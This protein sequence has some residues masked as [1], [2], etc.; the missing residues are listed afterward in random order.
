MYVALLFVC[1]VVRGSHPGS[2]LHLAGQWGGMTR[3]LGSLLSRV[4]DGELVNDRWK[5]NRRMQLALFAHT[6]WLDYLKDHLLPR[7][8][9]QVRGQVLRIWSVGCQTG[10]EAASKAPGE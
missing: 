6:T 10:D 5:G 1:S 7:I 3:E 8:L 4:Q 9:A 2:P